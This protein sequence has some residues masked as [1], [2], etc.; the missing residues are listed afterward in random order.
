MKVI[1]AGGGTGGH[2]F[3][4]IAIAEEIKRRDTQAGITF[5]GTERGIEASLIPREGYPLKYLSVEGI[6]GKSVLK[7][8]KASLKMLFSIYEAYKLL[9]DI[10]PDALVGVGGYASFSPVL[11][12]HFMSIPTMIMEQN[13]VPGLTNKLLGR[14]VDAVCLTY[15]ESLSAFPSYKTFVTGNPI[16]PSILT[17]NRDAAYQLFGLEKGKFTIFVFGGSTGA[18]AINNA[19]CDAFNYM[20][21]LKDKIQFLHQT[22]SNGYEAAREAY[23]KC[24]FKGTVAAFVHQMPEAYAVADLVISRAGAT[25]ITELTSVGRPA[26]LIPYPYAA[27]NHQEANARRLTEMGAARLISEQDLNGDTLSSNIRDLFADNNLR[28]DMQKANKSLGRP[29]AAKK[30]VDIL[31]SL[32]KTRKLKSPEMKIRKAVKNV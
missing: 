23:R 11:A 2:I 13:T 4:G 32:L 5:I 26:V 22:G 30:V 14:I 31:F 20:S 21:D 25:T 3:P 15:H 24:G 29:D 1:I 16:R 6:V 7:K 18:R 10:R 28:A 17:G 27:G 9:R 12:A 19:V 8:A